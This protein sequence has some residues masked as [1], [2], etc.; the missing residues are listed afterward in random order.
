MRDKR[1]NMRRLALI[2]LLMF[3]TLP[4]AAQDEPIPDGDFIAVRLTCDNGFTRVYAISPNGE[5]VIS[6]ENDP[7]GTLQWTQDGESLLDDEQDQFDASDYGID[8]L[9]APA[10][11]PDGTQIAFVSEQQAEI[12]PTMTNALTVI[13]VESGTVTVLEDRLHVLGE[14]AWSPDGTQLAFSASVTYV[15]DPGNDIY[16]IDA[17]GSNVRNITNFVGDESQPTWSADGE[18]L[19]FVYDALDFDDMRLVV[20]DANGGGA[21]VLVDGMAQIDQPTWRPVVSENEV[22]IDSENA[23]NALA[24]GVIAEV[25]GNQGALRLRALP[26]IA[27]QAITAM[28]VGTQVEII[29]DS[30]D[31]DGYTWWQM[32]LEDGRTGWAVEAAGG[33]QTLTA[34]GYADIA[35]QPAQIPCE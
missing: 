4:L 35:R 15:D 20:M 2:C 33:D 14:I 28:P 24:F 6:V 8:T 26:S 25:S 23:P 13:D 29:G 11:S 5:T 12:D 9:F 16:L 32:R 17:D 3:L 34:I 27:G 19:A 10:W 1:F 30:Q 7:D 31:A 18:R 21:Y 22:I